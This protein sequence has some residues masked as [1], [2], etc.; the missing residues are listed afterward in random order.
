MAQLRA[1]IHLSTKQENKKKLHNTSSLA[2]DENDACVI[3][4]NNDNNDYNNVIIS[5]NE[6]N[7]EENVED[8]D[9]IAENITTSEEI[10]AYF[11]TC[12]KMIEEE[13]ISFEE[14]DISNTI[15]LP[16][17]IFDLVGETEHPA[18]NRD[19]KW[20]LK[21]LFKPLNIPYIMD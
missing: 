20:S 10:E 8:G 16:D 12:E 21:D 15:F 6:D 5:N 3:L 4:D 1:A 19:A 13:T 2:L 11:R 7:R 17:D 14:E 9:I 18:N